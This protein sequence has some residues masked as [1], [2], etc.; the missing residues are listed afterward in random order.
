MLHWVQGSMY[1]P[2]QRNYFPEW[3][4]KKRHKKLAVAQNSSA[5]VQYKQQVTAAVK[6]GLLLFT[7]TWMSRSSVSAA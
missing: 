1:R 2:A 3:K 5:T 6:Y 4:K 7:E